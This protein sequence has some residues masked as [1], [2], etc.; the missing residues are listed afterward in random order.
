[1]I[2]DRLSD[3]QV[4]QLTGLGACFLHFHPDQP[5][6]LDTTHVTG[7]LKGD[8]AVI[9]AAVAGTDYQS[10]IGTISG[11]AKG[12]GANALTAAVV[13]TD[14]A[15]PTTGLAT[16]ILKNTT[17]TGAHSIA[18]SGTDYQA[19]IGTI[20]GIA[21]G[22]GANALTAAVS[23]T[24]YQA[25]IG[26]ISGIA[27]GNGTNT[28]TAAISGTDYQAPI[29]TISG[30]A[31]GNGANALTAAVVGTDY[32]APIGTISG[33]AKGNGANALTAAVSGT[34]YLAPGA[35]GTTVQAYDAQLSSLIR[36]VSQT[37][38]Y[39]LV[40]TDVGKHILHPT[41]DTTARTFTIPANASVAF[42][43]GTSVTFVNQHGAGVITISITT[44]SMY[45][46][47]AG[48][49]GSRTL[50]ANG[51]ATALKITSTEWIIS[52]AGLT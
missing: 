49:T 36:Q 6:Q 45:L 38:N 18:I 8:G 43:I 23:G 42:P 33:I 3:Q 21:K 4:A 7:I 10:P 29:G 34:D 30:I 37:T 51:I 1:M 25:P 48:S 20:S 32:Q 14:Y 2:D 24:D 5:Q 50:A 17:V 13:R 26:T 44:D 46:A 16:G 47:G 19:P 31:K 9:S 15:E 28:L 27:K 40:A 52:G 39:T 22:N 35:I 12:N 11:I 41:S